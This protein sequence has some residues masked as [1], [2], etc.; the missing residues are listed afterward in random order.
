MNEGHEQDLTRSL[1]GGGRDPT[2]AEA[3]G[4]DGARQGEP[5][6]PESLGQYRILRLIGEGG[7]GAV[8]EAE[9]K[10]PRRT[11]ALKVIRPGYF[12]PELLRRFELES[13]VLGRLQHPGIAQIYEAG[14]FANPE[15]GAG[16]RRPPAPIPFFAM[17]FVRG[18]PLTEYAD[19]RKLGTRERLELLAKICDAVYHAHQKGVIHRDL[20]PSNILVTELDSPSGPS[21]QRAA[22]ST[23]AQP[24][25]L[26]FGVARATD[27]DIQQ[28]TMQTDVGQLIGTVPYMSPE[29][30]TGDPNELDT[31]SDVY[32]L[33]VIAYELLA[34][35]LPHDLRRKMI[36]EA[37]RIIREEEPTRLSSIN[38]TLRGDVETIVAKALE[39]EK[40]RRYQSAESLASDIRRYLKD[41]PIAARP[42]GTWYQ[43][44]KFA[45]RNRG[46]VT[47]LAAAFV[48][49]IAGVI[50]TGIGLKQAVD[51]RDA[52]SVARKEADTQRDAAVVAKVE[53]RKQ[54]EAA[55]AQRDK[56]EKIADFMSDT[57]DGV[58]PSV[59]RGRDI[60]MLKEM[61]DAA[62]ARIEKGDLRD[63]P[64]A[65]L[66]LRG[67]IG[68][69]YRDLSL[70]PESAR[71]LEPIVA[72][73]RSLHEGDHPETAGALNRLARLLQ[74]RGDLP[75][76]EALYRD[77]LDM[78][79]RLHPGDHPDVAQGLNNL[80]ILLQDRGDLAT[81]ERL[82]REAL[83][84]WRRVFPGDHSDVA[85]GLNNLALA[86]K[87]RGDLSGA[88]PLYR[89][90]LEMWQRLFPGDHPL[91]A[92]GLSNLAS[93]LKERADLTGAEALFRRALNMDR[94][95]FG[96]DSTVVAI[97]LNNLAGVLFRRADMT[98]AES[99]YREALEMTRRLFPGDHPS[100][101]SSLNNL[102]ALLQARGAL[103]DAEPLF[104]EALEMRERLFPGDHP[105]VAQGL[106]N[107]ASV[108]RDRG[109]LAG[110]EPLYK[111]ALEMYRRLFPGDHPDVDIALNNVA[112][113]LKT[114][115]DLAGAEPLFR[116]ALE[117]SRRL[118]PGDHPDV[119]ISLSNLAA[120]LN[121]RG[122][123][124]AAEPLYREA[125]E[126]R[127]RVMG[128]D[129]PRTL[130]SLYNL[131][132]T[133]MMQERYAEAAPL[134][135]QCVDGNTRRFGPG[136]SETRD[137]IALAVTLHESWH[138]AEP[139]RGHD[140][141]AAEWK[142]KL[143]ALAPPAEAAPDAPK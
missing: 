142:A 137:A 83:E 33:G 19:S 86:L 42:A 20:K 88:E 61:M 115:G 105:E 63:A 109:D 15:E 53:E 68:G 132:T 104:R 48:L 92:M 26:D 101:A 74:D 64:E 82:C 124:G 11:V 17:E 4:A 106:N 55:E 116:E 85:S 22:L 43:A 136:H 122:D 131:V 73:A 76:A 10:S 100:V 45:K 96:A 16:P 38:R 117:M 118:F 27:S 56:A 65:E 9:Q 93:L 46:L 127:R 35:R 21:T 77:A 110:A 25:I 30:V 121:A 57:L 103:D 69:T 3:A 49:L 59:A 40:T 139:G 81:S 90:S 133:L 2:G 94:R 71:M 113:L 98:G 70:Y 32:A 12:T 18:V 91:V 130:V 37:A 80:G 119:A 34:G 14:V 5:P 51:A 6:V 67:T 41:E 78:T 29:Q 143:D 28:T 44:A 138:K 23:S 60:T 62:A 140:A 141:R 87:K 112:L 102:A 126:M 97:D 31:R 95:L 8:Y 52:E 1:G 99:L 72:L 79:R 58:G 123:A 36:H 114:R 128:E 111:G 107:L 125:F 135:E 54:R 13:Q 75:G 84:M 89:E 24:K 50:G 134:A 120:L 7:M 47:G 129:H 39:K 108:C 66:R